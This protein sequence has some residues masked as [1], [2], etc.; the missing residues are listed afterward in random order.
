MVDTAFFKF[1]SKILGS[2]GEIQP[3]FSSGF[4]GLLSLKQALRKDKTNKIPDMNKE[5]EGS[6]CMIKQRY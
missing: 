6:F 4:F 1:S 5:I 2:A 3:V